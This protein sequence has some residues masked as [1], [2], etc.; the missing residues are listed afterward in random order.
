VRKSAPLPKKL[1]TSYSFGVLDADLKVGVAGLGAAVDGEQ[2][3]G[4]AAL[5]RAELKAGAAS[6][7]ASL[8]RSAVT[9]E[10]T[11]RANTHVTAEVTAAGRSI[12]S[13]V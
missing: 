1:K 7:V 12:A 4:H 13:L 2:E 5:A 10:S 6:E 3:A 11:Q 9:I 8:A